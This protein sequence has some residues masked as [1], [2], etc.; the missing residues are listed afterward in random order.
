MDK[1]LFKVWYQGAAALKY[2]DK[3]EVK[4]FAE[5]VGWENVDVEFH[6]LQSELDRNFK[7]AMSRA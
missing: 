4:A 6:C 2:A 7:A 5:Q 3:D 1:M